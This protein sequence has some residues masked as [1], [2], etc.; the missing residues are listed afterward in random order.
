MAQGGNP[1]PLPGGHAQTL[2]SGLAA[3]ISPPQRYHL[4]RLGDA[5][6]GGRELRLRE[7]LGEH[8]TVASFVLRHFGEAAHD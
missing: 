7:R 6:D 5:A 2:K 8:G 4:P 3:S 1:K